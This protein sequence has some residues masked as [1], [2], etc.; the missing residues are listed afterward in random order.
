MGLELELES[1]VVLPFLFMFF[2]IYLFGYF[3]LFRNWSPKIRPE[4][5]SCLISLFHGTPAAILGSAAIIA[6]QNRGFVAANTG[7]QKLVLDYSTAYFLMDLLHYLVFFPGDVLFIAHHLATLF[8]IVTCRHAVS[9]GAFSVIVLLVLAE[10][11]S[12]CQNA[13]TLAAARRRE[14]R[15]AAKVFDALS[16]PFYALYSVVRG[17]VGPYYMYRMVV[18]YAGGGA[19]GLVPRWVWVSWV[20]VVV[21]AIGVSIMWISNL[22]LELY[23]KR[24]RKLDEKIR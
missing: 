24:T 22:W 11:T 4:S 3:I 8:V 13:W 20:V 15:F 6:D 9:H 10:V 12:A 2:I 7:F 5:A 23:R 17:F 21:M 16:L 18:F 1:F 14:D 19:D